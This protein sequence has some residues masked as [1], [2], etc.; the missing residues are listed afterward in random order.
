M[1]SSWNDLPYDIL[2]Q[3]IC[4]VDPA[5]VWTCGRASIHWATTARQTACK[6]RLTVEIN[7]AAL[8]TKLTTLF[9]LRSRGRLCNHYLLLHLDIPVSLSSFISIL[10]ALC[11]QHAPLAECLIGVDFLSNRSSV[12]CLT[13]QEGLAENQNAL[14]CEKQQKLWTEHKIRIGQRVVGDF[15]QNPLPQLRDTLPRP[16]IAGQ[17]VRYFM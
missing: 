7:P 5:D 4:H 16:T 2:T 17:K 8:A 13:R 10:D 1:S 3:A 12:K 14:F 15:G 6:R 11:Q 9:S